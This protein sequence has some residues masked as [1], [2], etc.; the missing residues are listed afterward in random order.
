MSKTDAWM[1]FYVGDY[2]SDTGRLTTEQHGAYLLILLD[3]WKNGPPPDDNFVLAALARMTPAVWR[4]TRPALIGFF[5]VSDGKLIQKRAERERIK[6]AAIKKAYSERAK[7]GAAKR[8]GND[9]SSNQQGYLD[10]SN[11]RSPKKKS[12]VGKEPTG[13]GAPDPLKELFDV[14]VQILTASGQ[15]EKQARSLIGKWRKAKQSDGD[16]LTGLIACRTQV[17]SNPVEWLEKRF[18]NR[19]YVSESGFEY[20]G[21]PEQV[22]RKAN[23]RRDFDTVWKVE[24]D[25]EEDA[26]GE[27]QN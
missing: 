1:P 27:K 13:A 10:D 14:G 2:L 17:I 3:Y 11:L 8:W 26:L 19:R 12:S 5:K 23:E 25:M 18:R 20:R 6:T 22:R 9:A 16:V 24:R 21:T 15:S 4:R 7:K